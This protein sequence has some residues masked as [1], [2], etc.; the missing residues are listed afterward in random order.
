MSFHHLF[1]TS[2]SQKR[3]V[4]VGPLLE[5]RPSNRQ[6]PVSYHELLY[7]SQPIASMELHTSTLQQVT[8]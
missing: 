4:Q 1:L 7:Q 2:L 3:Q 8:N 6:Q 5:S